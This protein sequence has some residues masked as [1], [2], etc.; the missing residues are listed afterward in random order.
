MRL[1]S[2][3]NGV[4]DDVAAGFLLQRRAVDDGLDVSVVDAAG[5]LVL[6]LDRR[7]LHADPRGRGRQVVGWGRG[8]V[9]LH[10]YGVGRGRLF[11]RGQ[12]VVVVDGA[13]TVAA[14]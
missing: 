8:R 14:G 1:G 4:A 11:Q 12:R 10:V 7:R 13:A 5:C 3:D 6:A 2:L 9:V